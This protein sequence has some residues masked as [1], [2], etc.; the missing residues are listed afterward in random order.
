VRLDADM[1]KSP[2]CQSRVTDVHRAGNASS[3]PACGPSDLPH[4]DVRNADHDRRP[5][6]VT[7]ERPGYHG[8]NTTVI[9][10]MLPGFEKLTVLATFSVGLPVPC[11]VPWFTNTKEPAG[12]GPPFDVSV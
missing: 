12:V 7:R 8:W 11:I 4:E 10:V 2:L 5:D 1:A 6:E 3:E 9:P